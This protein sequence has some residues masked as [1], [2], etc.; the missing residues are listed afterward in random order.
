MGKSQVKKTLQKIQF[1]DKFVL[2]KLK[3]YGIIDEYKEIYS[4]LQDSIASLNQASLLHR[5]RNG[6]P[7]EA[8][9]V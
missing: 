5:E 6:F 7:S 9:L 4:I 2:A 8:N 1:F 3:K